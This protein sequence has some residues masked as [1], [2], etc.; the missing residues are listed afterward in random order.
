MEHVDV[1]LVFSKRISTLLNDVLNHM[2]IA[3]KRRKMEG[4]KTIITPALA[5]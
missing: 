4:S 2:I 3:I 5:I 1:A